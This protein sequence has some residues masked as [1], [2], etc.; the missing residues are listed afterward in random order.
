V[1]T[2]AIL[3]GSLGYGA[4]ARK[5]ASTLLPSDPV[6]LYLD[7]NDEALGVLA[8]ATTSPPAARFLWHQR[9]IAR[10]RLSEAAR[11]R[12]R[13]LGS[14]QLRQPLVL[15]RLEHADF[16]TTRSLSPF[17]PALVLLE[18]TRRAHGPNAEQAEIAARSFYG[19][20]GRPELLSATIYEKLGIDPSKAVAAF[21]TELA[22]LG[23]SKGALGIGVMIRDYERACMYSALRELGLMYLHTLSSIE[24]S[25]AFA[26]DLG[27][28]AG[29]TATQFKRWYDYQVASRSG[30]GVTGELLANIQK[31]DGF[32]GRPLIGIFDELSGRL[33]WGSPV[34][35]TAARKIIARLDTR[36]EH[37][38]FVGRL[39]WNGLLDLKLAETMDVS[40]TAAAPG[41]FP[42]VETWLASFTRDPKVLDAALALPHLPGE[43]RIELLKTR[44]RVGR[45]DALQTAADI[46]RV[47]TEHFDE[48]MP[49]KAA[50]DYFTDKGDY[51]SARRMS[52]EWVEKH[53]H[54]PGLD[55]VFARIALANSLRALDR[56]D[57]AYAAIQPA[58]A[59]YQSGAM[60]QAATLLATKGKVDE[61]DR[62]MRARLERYPYPDSVGGVAE[63]LWR[64]GNPH[65]AA[66]LLATSRVALRAVEWRENIG[67]A[68][69]GGFR[70]IESAG[71]RRSIRRA[72]EGEY[73]RGEPAPGRQ[74]RSGRQSSA[75][76]LRPALAHR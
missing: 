62:L 32:G 39:A 52:H 76:R 57:E 44:E 4:A 66:T 10:G 7:E 70:A 59:S 47:V 61:A 71:R 41:A 69:G 31:L 29:S 2:R 8:A 30:N 46:T 23:E 35:I 19:R 50:I 21:D 25:K 37:R 3:A 54:A 14:M 6:R 15:G 17:A 48:W 26:I 16:E 64:E 24:A 49:Q 72:Q 65:G 36:P 73:R 63:V 20:E 1:A 43:D 28:D 9:L 53:P 56:N 11:F 34:S 74:R 18:T 13:W 68:F 27:A 12:A 33:D 51:E 22:R 75:A 60:Y 58:V 40:A 67:R 55:G 45:A 38:I 5:I 42:H